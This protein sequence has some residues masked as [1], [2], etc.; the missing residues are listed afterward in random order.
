MEQGNVQIK[1][2]H[3]CTFQEVVGLWN[4]GFQEY[5]QD[6]SVETDAFFS[7]LGSQGISIK[8]SI[9][10]YIDQ[11]PAGFVLIGLKTINGK[12][13][14]WNGGTGIV[15][16]FRGKGVAKILM[17]ENT[18]TLRELKVDSAILEVVTKNVKAIAAYQRGGYEIAADLVSLK[19]ESEFKQIPFCGQRSYYSRKAL[20]RETGNLPFY[21]YSTAW[22][23][24]WFNVKD[25]ESLMLYD[26][27]GETV[28][29]AIYK[30]IFDEQ[31]QLST[32][33]LHHCEAK[34]ER[35]DQKEIIRCALSYVFAPFDQPYK[36]E[37]TDMPNPIVV[38]ILKEEGFEVLH[39]QYLMS[40]TL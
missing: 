19:R 40:M 37:T 39:E 7:R 1:K 8:H 29:Y 30:K 36:R 21:N 33:Q 13:M 34:P 32:I 25:G 23:N 27:Y 26:I 4:A 14:A 6:M 18:R 35:E 12:K 16:K 11:E 17:S 9:A 2:L 20:P 31:G 24:Q 10:A 15:P 3:T 5:F 28:G 38:E 22:L